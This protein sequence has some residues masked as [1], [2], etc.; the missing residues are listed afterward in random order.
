MKSNRMFFPTAALAA[1]LFSA[2]GITAV[3][4]DD[5]DDDGREQ[6]ISLAETPDAVKAAMLVELL[7][8]VDEIRLAKIERENEGGQ[9]IYEAEFVYRGMQIELEFSADGRLL[10]KEIGHDEAEEEDDD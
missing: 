1:A 10:D 9:I 6:V 3:I 8:E 2:Y 4:D 7:G 5:D